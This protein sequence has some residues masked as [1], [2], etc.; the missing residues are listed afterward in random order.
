MCVPI[1]MGC[2]PGSPVDFPAK[3][4][5]FFQ[6]GKKKPLESFHSMVTYQIDRDISGHRDV[7][8]GQ[9]LFQGTKVERQNSLK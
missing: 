5:V 2:D 7:F 3:R 9:K 1:R 4:A 8:P 6:K